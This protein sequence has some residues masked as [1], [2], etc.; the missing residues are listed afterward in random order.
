MFASI[1]QDKKGAF[2]L[3]TPKTPQDIFNEMMGD[4]FL[5]R[6]LRRQSALTPEDLAISQ[7]ILAIL[8][9]F[10]GQMFSENKN[11]SY[12]NWE[13]V[14]MS[15]QFLRKAGSTEPG[16]LIK[17]KRRLDL[18]RY[19]RIPQQDG[20]QR[21]C[22][23]A[24]SNPNYS[25]TKEEKTRLQ[26]WEQKIVSNFF[27][28]A[29]DQSPNFSKFIGNAYEDW[30]DIDDITNEIVRD[31]LYIPKSIHIQDAILYKPVVKKRRTHISFLNTGED[32]LTEEISEEFKR[33]NGLEIDEEQKEPD[34]LM[35]YKDQLI[36]PYSNEI[37][38][39]HHFFTRSDFRRAQRGYS[40][41]EQGISILTNIINSLTQNATNFTKNRQPDGLLAF[42]GGGVG[43]AALE[44]IKKILSAYADGPSNRHRYPA[45]GLQGEKSDVKWV[46]T[47]GSSKDMEYHLWITLLFSIW[48]QLSGTDPR[49]IS[50]GSH[51]DAVSK[52]SLA[53]PS[54]DGIIKENKDLGIE[55]FLMHLE[56]SLNAPGKYGQNI[57]QEI[58]KMDCR[59]KFVGFEMTD[60]KLKQELTKVKLETTLSLNEQLATE[61]KEPYTLMVGDVNIYDVPGGLNPTITQYINANA[62]RKQQEQMAPGGGVPGEQGAE[63][64]PGEQGKPGETKLT[65]SDKELLAHY[66]GAEDVNIEQGLGEE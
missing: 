23:L 26:I 46:S 66:G 65:D 42:T 48:C 18:A 49:E 36:A 12:I 44:K 11:H 21:G 29:N 53:A 27:Y 14:D 22:G 7:E 15:Y 60:K 6:D 9:D 50:L 52:A 28:A 19:G 51:S 59:L 30:F 8:N 43:T 62:M 1:D 3:E 17:N 37:I 58:T 33:L 38:R 4:S 20:I 5:Q 32:E 24:F 61:D 34:Y 41:V 56:D 54:A 47:R 57:F 39:K 13:T 10:E 64:Q 31:G 2:D 16:R 63:P 55:T 45:I 40:I 35:I 25:P